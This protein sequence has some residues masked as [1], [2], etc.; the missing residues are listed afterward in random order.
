V[1]NVPFKKYFSDIAMVSF[2]DGGNQSTTTGATSGAGNEYTSVAP[3]FNSGVWW[4][5]S[6]SIFI[7][8]HVSN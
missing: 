5:S 7:S 8:K 6:L 2:I 1:L 3:E 4:G